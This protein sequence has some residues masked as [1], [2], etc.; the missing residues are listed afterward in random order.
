VTDMPYRGRDAIS[1]AP[2]ELVRHDLVGMP[3]R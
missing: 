3:A 1:A 2:Y